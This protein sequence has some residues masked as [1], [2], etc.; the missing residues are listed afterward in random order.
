M[1]IGVCWHIF[2]VN[3]VDHQ[4]LN[5]EVLALMVMQLVLTSACLSLPKTELHNKNSLSF[6]SVFVVQLV[7]LE[8]SVSANAE[9]GADFIST[10]LT[11]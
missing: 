3:R 7:S 9:K 6:G 4:K 5:L 8:K 2:L 11:S 1:F 10:F